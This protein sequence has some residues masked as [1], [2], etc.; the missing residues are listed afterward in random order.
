MISTGYKSLFSLEKKI[1]C[2]Q[3][4]TPTVYSVQNQPQN[5]TV[6]LDYTVYSVE[7]TVELTV[8][9]E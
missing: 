7:T 1:Q 8:E 6:D 2:F 9:L 3:T 5:H 4:L